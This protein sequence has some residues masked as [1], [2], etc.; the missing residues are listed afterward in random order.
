MTDDRGWGSRLQA[1]GG[2]L[3]ARHCIAGQG[4]IG[5]DF[6]RHLNEGRYGNVFPI[7]LFILTLE[8]NL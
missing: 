5:R 1:Y 3:L 7:S 6:K 4:S 8:K 2:R